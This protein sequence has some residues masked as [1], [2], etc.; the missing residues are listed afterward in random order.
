MRGRREDSRVFEK[1]GRKTAVR[2][3]GRRNREEIEFA[4]SFSRNSL[5]E[6]LS[7]NVFAAK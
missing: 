6:G 1:R 7:M 5:Q 2:M 4:N 3:R